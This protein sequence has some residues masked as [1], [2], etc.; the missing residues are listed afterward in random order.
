MIKLILISAVLI[1]GM[2]FISYQSA[3][4]YFTATVISTNNTF[5]TADEFA[6]PTPEEDEESLCN[7]ISVDISGNGTGSVNG[8]VI[9]CDNN[10]VVQQHNETNTNTNINISSNTG[11]NEGGDVVTGDSSVNVNISGGKN[12]NSQ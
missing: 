2:G 3:S 7:E 6:T 12:I 9:V 8:V 5:S 11:N 10:V 1:V 4:S